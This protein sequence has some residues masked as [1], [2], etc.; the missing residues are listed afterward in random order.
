[1]DKNKIVVE[2]LE[3]LSTSAKALHLCPGDSVDDMCLAA[4]LID[5]FLGDLSGVPRVSPPPDLGGGIPEAR[6]FISQA[7]EKAQTFQFYDPGNKAMDG[8]EMVLG[9]IHEFRRGLPSL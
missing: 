7:I 1:M 3:D 5:E 4:R 8:L 2:I 9:A 6:F